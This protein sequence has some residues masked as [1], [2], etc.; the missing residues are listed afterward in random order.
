MKKIRQVFLGFGAGLLSILMVLGSFSI[1]FTEGGF[2]N[3]AA[4]RLTASLTPGTTQIL[5][6]TSVPQPEFTVTPVLSLTEPLAASGTEKP[7][8]TPSC[9]PPDGWVPITVA[10]GDT[11]QSLAEAS[12]TTMAQLKAGNCLVSDTVFPGSTLFV[13]GI[14]TST[15]SPIPTLLSTCSPP[16]GWLPYTI[17]VGDSLYSIGLMVGASVIDLQLANCMGLQ[18]DIR[19]GDILYVPFIPA[20]TRTPTPVSTTTTT[21]PPLLDTRTPTP[22]A[23]FTQAAPATRTPT[24]SLTTAPMNTVTPTSTPTPTPTTT[25]TLTATFTTTPTATAT[26]TPTPTD[27]LTPEPTLTSTSSGP[28]VP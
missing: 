9:P 12:G 27:T 2:V 1:A 8:E 19:A 22:P 3:L 18:T 10:P 17:R 20:S 4:L 11:L 28:A 6:L 7:T 24:P 23:T 13:P 16:P 21:V 26:A 5:P 15:P 14:P 25:M